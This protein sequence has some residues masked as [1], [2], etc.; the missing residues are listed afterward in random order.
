VK[1][2]GRRDRTAALRDPAGHLPGWAGLR[3]ADM[4]AGYATEWGDLAGL[5]GLRALM[6]HPSPAVQ[7]SNGP[8]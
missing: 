7:R 6:P 8:S 4:D 2:A 5:G 1:A 3:L